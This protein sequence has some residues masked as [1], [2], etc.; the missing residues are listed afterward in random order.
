M[1]EDKNQ[2]ELPDEYIRLSY[3]NG[4][5]KIYFPVLPESVE[6]KKKGRGEKFDIVGLGEVNVI[7]SR[8]LAEVSFSSFFPFYDEKNKPLT[9]PPYVSVPSK[10]W[11]KP[12]DYVDLI[13]KWQESK[14]PCR[15]L[16]N[17]QGLKF[18][19]AVSIEQFDRREVAGHDGDVEFT[20]TFKEYKFYS[21]RKLETKTD[22]E[23][24]KTTVKEQPPQRPDERVPPKTYKLKKG[25]NLWKVARSQLGD[26]TRWREIMLLN[27]LTEADCKKL[28]IGQ[29]LI[30][31]ERK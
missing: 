29:V 6:V 19:I 31:P 24:G 9:R 4:R 28:Q 8:E 5:Q 20:L 21:V 16:V 22:P 25:D 14:Y 13:N 18:T 15:L 7:Q 3:D 27:K 12:Q 23:T 11:L 26:D 2:E 30:L 17:T 10:Q 1:A